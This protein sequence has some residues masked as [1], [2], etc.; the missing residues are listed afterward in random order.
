MPWLINTWRQTLGGGV[1]EKC[2]D[3]MEQTKL[4]CCEISLILGL[5]HLIRRHITSAVEVTLFNN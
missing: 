2:D 3:T 4:H 5:S 1:M